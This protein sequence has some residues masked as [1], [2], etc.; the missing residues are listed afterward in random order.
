MRAVQLDAALG[1]AA[2]ALKCASASRI[3]S[4]AQHRALRR[5]L[6]RDR[7]AEERH[8][9]VAGQLRDDALEAVDLVQRQRDVLLEQLAEDFRIEPAGHRGR[10][11]K[12]AEQH[13]DLLALAGQSAAQGA[14]LLARLSGIGLGG[15]SSQSLQPQRPGVAGAGAGGPGAVVPPPW[16]E[17]ATGTEAKSRLYLL[18]QRGQASATRVPQT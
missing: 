16:L 18:E 17:A 14:D 2:A 1:F 11:G 7:R 5:V 6:V 4:A 9:A 13:G 10:T 15:S 8:E 12:I 3:A